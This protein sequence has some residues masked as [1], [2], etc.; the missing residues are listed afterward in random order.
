MKRCFLLFIKVVVIFLMLLPHTLS[1][2]EQIIAD[3]RF[4]GNKTV[5]DTVILSKI[6]S[7]KGHSF[8]RYTLNQDLKRI[9]DLGY[10]SQ[11]SITLDESFEGIIITFTVQEKPILKEIVFEGNRKFKEKKLRKKMSVKLG[12]I[13]DESEIKADVEKIKAFYE[14]KGFQLA[15]IDY[16]ISVD[17]AA[18]HAILILTIEEKQKIRTERIIFSGV[19]SIKKKKLLKL[20]KTKKKS[21][22]TSG[23]LKKGE[24]DEDLER[25]I[26]FYRS[27][28]FLDAKLESVEITPGKNK[29]RRIITITIQ[30]GT[31]YYIGNILINGIKR[32]PLTDILASMTLKKSTVFTPKK[33]HEDIMLIRDYYFSKG[34]VDAVVTYETV[35]NSTTGN[36]DIIFTVK[37]GDIS[38]VGKIVIQGNTKTKDI[39]IRREIKIKPGEIFNGVKVKRSQERL[40]N[41][42]FFKTVFFDIQKTNASD[43]KDLLVEVEESKTG[44]LGFG[45]GFSSIDKLIGFVEITQKN[46]DLF[47]FP[48]FTGDGQKLRFRTQ[49]GK[50]RRDFIISFTE[51][52]LFNKQLSF[53]FDLYNRDRKYLSDVYDEKKT[54]GNL[55]LGKRLTEFIRA[56]IVYTLET[57]EITDVSEDASDLIKIEEGK[58]T[59]SKTGLTLTRDTRDNYFIPKRGMINSLTGE[60]AGGFL[61]GDRDF[62][63]YFTKNSIYFPLLFNVVLRLTVQAGTID[64]FG[65][66]DRVPIFERYFLGGSNSIRGF[67]YRDVGPKDEFGEPIGG[68]SMFAA[69]AEFTFPIIKKIRGAVFYDTG[70]VWVGPTDF[71]FGDL[72]AGVGVGLRIQLPI[73]PIQ[74]D[75]GYPLETDEFTEEKGR[76]HFNIGYL[77]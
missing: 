23:V 37:E 70:N 29:S 65:D 71:D 32:F 62:T 10:F 18:G 38:K 45:A 50:E 75:Y 60:Y 2:E 35:V 73:G 36:L 57:V 43:V 77:F 63:K 19:T 26:N 64:F 24:F 9:Y 76:V 12:A 14:E 53:G 66:S 54:G 8:S 30:E 55:K 31:Q 58:N 34:Y 13:L 4:E 22:F 3:I 7:Q 27:K 42:G 25:I 6:K 11:I 69:T 51:P 46:F 20:M 21:L 15:T 52:W 17:E 68:Q 48:R 41:L 47:N 72:R 33:L 5:S 1:E 16:K 49:F 56:D 59:I 67:K 40:L 74:I 28:G 39:V 61:E 44:E